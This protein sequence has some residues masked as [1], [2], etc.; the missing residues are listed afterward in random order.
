ME[1]NLYLVS[2][3]NDLSFEILHI[4]SEKKSLFPKNTDL[5]SQ[6]DCIFSKYWRCQN[7][8][9]VSYSNDYKNN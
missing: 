3:N 8:D 5:V 7:I 9:L 6:N 2:L 4:I 1:I